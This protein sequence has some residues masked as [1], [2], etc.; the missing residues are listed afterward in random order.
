[1]SALASASAVPDVRLDLSYSCRDLREFRET[2]A[3]WLMLQAFRVTSGLPAATYKDLK[4]HLGPPKSCVPAT[5]GEAPGAGRWWLH[6]VKGAG[7]RGRT[8]VLR[9]FPS[10]SAGLTAADARASSDF[11]EFDGHVP[12]AGPVLDPAA[13]GVVVSATQLEKAA[14]CPFRHFVRR[15]LG[16]DAIE[17][18]DRDREVWLD[19][20]TRGTLLHDLYAQLL[21]KCRDEAR[22]PTM[23]DAKWLEERGRSSLAELTVEMPPPSSEIEERETKALLEDLDLFVEVEADAGASNEAVGLEVAFGRGAEAATEPFADADPVEVDLGGGLTLTVAGTID[24]VDQVG[25]AEFEILDYKTGS[26]YEPNWKGMFAGGRRLQ[27]ALYGLAAVELLRRKHRKAKVVAGGY[28]F[29]SAKGQ[30]ERKR[31]PTQPRATVAAV[32]GDLREVIA[33]G[34][35][36]HSNDEEDCKWCDFGYACGKSAREAADA[37]LG[38]STLAPFVRLRS[39]E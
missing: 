39:H 28:Y 20:M 7:D 26:F 1:V 4:E 21:R 2:Y 29:P 25:D 16:V 6:G 30:R 31:I 17:A 15:G 10:L 34:L 3:S 35:F 14:E 5:A 12:E 8:A 11:T 36:V 32:L 37:K 33:S 19:P 27:H 13:A 38:D 9:E 18:G 23:A 24:R 22:R